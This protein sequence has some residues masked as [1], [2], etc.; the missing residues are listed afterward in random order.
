MEAMLY[1][2]NPTPEPIV[3]PSA[4]WDAEFTRQATPEGI[5]GALAYAAVR[6][7]GL[8]GVM[9]GDTAEDL[10]H[11]ALVAT[12]DG[13]IR[14]RPD[15]VSLGAHLCDRV[16]VVLKRG[17]RQAARGVQLDHLDENDEEGKRIERRHLSFATGAQ[18]AIDLRAGSRACEAA[19]WHLAVGDAAALAYM[20]AVLGG[21]DDDG[22]IAA[23]TGLARVEVRAARR[24]LRRMVKELPS[25]LRTRTRSLLS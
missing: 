15:R 9:C 13:L 16:K 25:A 7:A 4:A 3:W 24:R 18:D 14:W 2:D 10:V 22:E 5:E 19:L 23:A 11:D 20:T 6:L 21:A 8:D 12:C 1:E 17:R